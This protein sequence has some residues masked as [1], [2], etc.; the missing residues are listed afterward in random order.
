MRHT[1]SKSNSLTWLV[2]CDVL[3]DLTL[4]HVNIF[5]VCDKGYYWNAD[6]SKCTIC[7]QGEYKDTVSDD[8]ECSK[9]TD[10][11]AGS[12]TAD[13]TIPATDASFCGMP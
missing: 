3:S 11:K 10:I 9:C 4:Y 7:A 6:T 2:S 13:G 5:A 12:S 1:T 8:E